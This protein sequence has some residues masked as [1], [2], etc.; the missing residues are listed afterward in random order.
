MPLELSRQLVFELDAWYRSHQV[1]QKDLATEL[2]L[3]PQ[4]LSEILSLRNRPTAD[5]ILTIQTFLLKDN[6]MSIRTSNTQTRRTSNDED[7]EP[8]IDAHNGLPMTLSQSI[9]MIEQLRSEL[10]QLKSAPVGELKHAR[11]SIRRPDFSA[12]DAANSNAK[13]R[14]AR[15]TGAARHQTGATTSAVDVGF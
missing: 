2:E 10:K 7:A 8:P 1:R 9:E 12:C 11:V 13:A 4:Q 3:S 5:Q 15:A 6:P 14:G